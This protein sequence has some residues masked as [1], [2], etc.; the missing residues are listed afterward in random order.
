M[1]EFFQEGGGSKICFC[2]NFLLFSDQNFRGTN[3]SVE[4]ASRGALPTEEESQHDVNTFKGNKP[5]R[6]IAPRDSFAFSYFDIM[7]QHTHSL[8][9]YYM[10]DTSK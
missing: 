8:L 6:A 5:F 7:V 2:A 3:V 9:I 10:T 4:T 1:L